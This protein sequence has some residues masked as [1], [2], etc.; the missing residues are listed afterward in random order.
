MFWSRSR[1]KP[2]FSAGAGEKASAP[3]I[4]TILENFG[5]ILTIYTQTAR[6]K[7]NFFQCCGSASVMRIRIRDPKN[8]HMDPVPDP[9]G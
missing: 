1:P 3:K 8:V 6:K 4:E 2:D 9:R 5:Q 7:Y